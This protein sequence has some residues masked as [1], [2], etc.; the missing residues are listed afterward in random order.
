MGTPATPSSTTHAHMAT[1]TMTRDE[2]TNAYVH[3][4]QF[5]VNTR[6]RVF[7]RC[8]T[9]TI[10]DW[11][12]WY[13]SVL[14]VYSLIVTPGRKV[15]SQVR[16]LTRLMCLDGDAWAREQKACW[17]KVT[18]TLIPCVRARVCPRV[19]PLWSAVATSLLATSK[20][21]VSSLVALEM[22]AF[23]WR[24]D[25]LCVR[26]L[27]LVWVWGDKTKQKKLK[28]T[29]KYAVKTIWAHFSARRSTRLAALLGQGKSDALSRLLS[30]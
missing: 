3:F 13:S 19:C 24:S 23:C 29:S 1:V 9:S 10:P 11:T 5:P 17:P 27:P 16:A 4:K 25:G 7:S 8:R 26:S 20:T 18:V 22:K 28:L 30:I 15:T 12:T 6:L 21:L 14:W 2:A